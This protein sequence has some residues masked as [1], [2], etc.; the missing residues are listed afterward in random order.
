MSLQTVR[1]TEQSEL[2]TLQHTF[3]VYFLLHNAFGC[4]ENCSQQTKSETCQYI[5]H[6]NRTFG[7]HFQ[8]RPPGLAMTCDLDL[9]IM[10]LLFF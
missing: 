10:A 3:F 1:E 7:G 8:T 9:P 2:G 4:S 6:F 5:P